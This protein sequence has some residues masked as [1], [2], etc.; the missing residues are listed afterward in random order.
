MIEVQSLMQWTGCTL[1][2][3]GSIALARN[4]CFSGWGFVAYLVSD[5]AWLAYGFS[6]D[7]PALALQHSVF[8]A[9]STFGVWRWL[10]RPWIE[11][12]ADACPVTGDLTPTIRPLADR[13][14]S[15]GVVHAD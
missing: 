6:S 11:A 4:D 10:V 7:I 14:S 2:V 8:A 5:A 15:H 13:S 3:A 12:K 9:V 1:G